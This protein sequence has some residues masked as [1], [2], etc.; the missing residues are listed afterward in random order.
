MIGTAGASL[1]PFVLPSSSHPQSSLTA[2]DATSSQLTLAV[3]LGVVV[4]FLPLVVAYTS[5]A[6]RVMRGS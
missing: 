3:M 1:F 4:L 2:W 6:Y 5:W